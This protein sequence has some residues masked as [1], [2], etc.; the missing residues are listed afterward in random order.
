MTPGEA[1]T[2]QSELQL[3]SAVR[4]AMQPEDGDI[5]HAVSE[6]AEAYGAIRDKRVRNLSARLGKAYAGHIRGKVSAG[7]A[8]WGRRRSTKARGRKRHLRELIKAK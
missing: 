6:E 7:G 4:A 8:K 1:F 5:L 3:A 2:L